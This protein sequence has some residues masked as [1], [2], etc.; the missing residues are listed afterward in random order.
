MKF[1]AKPQQELDMEGVSSLFKTPKATHSKTRVTTEEKKTSIER[2]IRKCRMSSSPGDAVLYGLAKLMK[3]PKVKQNNEP[4]L[5]GVP[6]LFEVLEMASPI[7]VSNTP[8]LRRASDRVSIVTPLAMNKTPSLRMKESANDVVFPLPLSSTPSLRKGTENLNIVIAEGPH[9]TPLLPHVSHNLTVALAEEQ[10]QTPSLK[11]AKENLTVAAAETPQ[12][13]PS[14]KRPAENILVSSPL[15][16]SVTPSLKNIPA[17]IV[18]A[19]PVQSTPTAP[20]EIAK[21]SSTGKQPKTVAIVSPF[22]VQSTSPPKSKSPST[23][24]TSFLIQTVELSLPEQSVSSNNVMCKSADEEPSTSKTSSAKRSTRSKRKV[25]PEALPPAKRPRRATSRNNT[26]KVVVERL[27]LEAELS[28]DR[29]STR[30]SK[31]ATTSELLV[32]KKTRAGRVKQ[33]PIIVEKNQQ[34]NDLEEQKKDKVDSNGTRTSRARRPVPAKLTPCSVQPVP[35]QVQL[36]SPVQP[37][38]P[39]KNI[40]SKQP[41]SID[42]A[43]TSKTTRSTRSK[44]IVETDNARARRTTTRSS[45]AKAVNEKETEISSGRTSTRSDKTDDESSVTSQTQV[46][47]KTR[48]KS[49]KQSEKSPQQPLE[50]VVEVENKKDLMN[51]RNTRASRRKPAN[52]TAKVSA[53]SKSNSAPKIPT[54]SGKSKNVAGI[55]ETPQPLQFTRSKLEPII[56]VPTPLPTPASSISGGSAKKSLLKSRGSTRS[57][58]GIATVIEEVVEPVVPMV[59]DVS[60]VSK[61]DNK[62]T[63]KGRVSRT[64]RSVAAEKG[65]DIQKR[66]EKESVVNEKRVTR[67]KRGIAVVVEEENLPAPKRQRKETAEVESKDVENHKTT[68]EKEKRGGRQARRTAREEKVVEELTISKS[69]STR[70]KK[71]A[72]KEIEVVEETVVKYTRTTRQKAKPAAENPIEEK[73]VEERSKRARKANP[74]VQSTEEDSGS[75][76]KTRT[77]RQ[78]QETVQENVETAVEKEV[79]GSRKQ[80][81]RA[82]KTP[83]KAA[84]QVTRVTRSRRGAK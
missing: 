16:A 40:T 79:K 12:N 8:S 49:V 57:R 68:E 39:S 24:L 22:P 30:S 62:N 20:A 81:K 38:L 53:N 51:K 65:A 7:P 47:R 23:E 50:I 26:A 19:S 83:D 75:R 69:R 55:P 34:V 56:E 3:T 59:S 70:R 6:E 29:A 82:N 37:T 66:A 45:K 4:D 14:L 54:R 41:E 33:P 64:K 36:A 27:V 46:V 9:R 84:E 13:T 44:C 18:S 21:C 74:S 1:A 61:Q 5:E 77:T 35:P 76:R 11:Q 17:V 63:S 31:N 73:P 48:A 71:P 28:S 10:S 58:R 43:M 52:E 80:S 25:E 78:K 72:V 42:E 15:L 2:P 60:D 67:A 32:Q